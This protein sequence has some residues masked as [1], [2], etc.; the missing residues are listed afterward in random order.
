MFAVNLK[1][2]GWTPYYYKGNKPLIRYTDY[3]TG[4]III[5]T[6]ETQL[7]REI[8]ILNS[9]HGYGFLRDEII[10]EGVYRWDKLEP[11]EKI[12]LIQAP[13]PAP[14]VNYVK[15]AAYV[16]ET[17]GLFNSYVAKVGKTDF[18]ALTRDILTEFTKEEVLD[19]ISL[20]EGE[21]VGFLSALETGI[22]QGLETLNRL[23]AGEQLPAINNFLAKGD[24]IDL[25]TAGGNA[26]DD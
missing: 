9:I 6:S 17:K 25:T 1:D 18:V 13:V 16:K 20:T 2:G 26:T 22:P 5:T 7:L 19:I 24:A 11:I 23:I 15:S 3:D 4:T 21:L 10:E 14:P 12:S 8:R